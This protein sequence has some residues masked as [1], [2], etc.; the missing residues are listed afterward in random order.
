MCILIAELATYV[1]HRL[2]HE[3]ASLWR[4]HVIHHMSHRVTASNNARHHFLDNGKALFPTVLIFLFLDFSS[5]VTSSV[6]IILILGNFLFT[7]CHGGVSTGISLKYQ[8]SN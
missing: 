1:D 4:I 3:N 7:N 2:S 5:K 6:W 8:H